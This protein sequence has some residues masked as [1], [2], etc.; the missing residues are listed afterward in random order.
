MKVTT[1]GQVTIP[2]DIRE[3]AGIHPGDEVDFVLNGDGVRIVKAATD[4]TRGQ[5]LVARMQERARHARRAEPEMTTNDL[6][7]LI[8]GE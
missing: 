2:M 3:Q 8:R 6:M 1:K 5:Q 7:A 4:L